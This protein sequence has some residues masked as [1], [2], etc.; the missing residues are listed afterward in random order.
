M[1]QYN[2]GQ[3][4]ALERFKQQVKNQRDRFNAQNALVSPS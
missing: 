3:V 1:E 2:V 4:N